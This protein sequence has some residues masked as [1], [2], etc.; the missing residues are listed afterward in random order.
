MW[1]INVYK[2]EDEGKL[3]GTEEKKMERVNVFPNLPIFLS[4]ITQD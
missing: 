2:W 3:S 4:D 1:E